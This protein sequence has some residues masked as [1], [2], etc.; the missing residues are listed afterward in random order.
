MDWKVAAKIGATLDAERNGE[1]SP[2]RSRHFE[3][4]SWVDAAVTL[5]ATM[6][7]GLGWVWVEV[8]RTDPPRNR[9]DYVRSTAWV[10][11]NATE[12]R[13]RASELRA[14]RV[15]G[16]SEPWNEWTEGAQQRLKP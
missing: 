6:I 14:H 12:L 1:I 8:E 3:S 2:I 11:T 13:S 10:A 9:Y 4:E 16:G 7:F 15:E 5:L